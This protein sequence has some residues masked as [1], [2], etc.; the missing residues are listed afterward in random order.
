M[1]VLLF[2]RDTIITSV[3]PGDYDGDS[4]MDVLLTTE[5][6]SGDKKTHISIF[7]GHGQTLGKVQLI[8]SHLKLLYTVMLHFLK[9]FMSRAA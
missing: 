8:D 5:S 2:F 9:L 4:Q 3:V 1:S 7:W 6:N